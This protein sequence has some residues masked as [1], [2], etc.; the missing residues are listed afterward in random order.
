MKYGDYL[1]FHFKLVCFPGRLLAQ[2]CLME[3]T[4][5]QQ[6]VE[7]TIKRKLGADAICEP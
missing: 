3:S 4:A 5:G 6:A 2:V 7:S 1:V